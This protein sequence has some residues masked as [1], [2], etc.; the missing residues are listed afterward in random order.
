MSTGPSSL[1]YALQYARYKWSVIPMRPR[2]KRP[3]IKWQEFQ[4]R[5]ATE[6]E[7]KSWYQRWPDANVGVVTGSISGLLVLDIDPQHGGD[8]SLATWEKQNA[9]LPETV[10]AKSGGGGRHLY[11]LHPG[12]TIHNRVGIVAGIDLR[13]DG[14]CIVTPPSIHSSGNAYTW[15]SGHE[16]DK[17]A[18]AEMPGWLFSLVTG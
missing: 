18:L 2:D 4:Q 3:M 16:P 10:E 7:I 17:M 9:E 1:E 11:F 8:K 6:D 15:L 13:G 12:E 14:G 5:C